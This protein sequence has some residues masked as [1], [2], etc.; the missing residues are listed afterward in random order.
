MTNDSFF[1]Q[2]NYP[3]LLT[4]PLLIET[5][6]NHQVDVKHI[7]LK[8]T[9]NRENEVREE[10]IQYSPD[11]TSATIKKIDPDTKITIAINIFYE[12]PPGLEGIEVKIERTTLPASE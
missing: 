4:D 1:I 7:L 5:D 2:W 3:T 12:N 8:I 10:I 9:S 6:P 11:T